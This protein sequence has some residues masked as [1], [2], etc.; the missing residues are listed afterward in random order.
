[1][2][3]VICDVFVFR[4]VGKFGLLDLEPVPGS[5]LCGVAVLLLLSHVR[6][7]DPV[8]VFSLA[9]QIL[10]HVALHLP[11]NLSWTA[12]LSDPLLPRDAFQQVEREKH[13]GEIFLTFQKRCSLADRRF[14]NTQNETA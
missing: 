4:E 13:G 8:L 2:T 6:P 1:M 10:Q 9:L 5:A 12:I 14:K 11:G 7:A 3:Q